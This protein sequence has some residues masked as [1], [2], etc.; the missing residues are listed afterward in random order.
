VVLRQAQDKDD[1]I[2]KPM[3]KNREEAG[4]SLGEKIKREIKKLEI[5]KLLVLAIP[6][7]GVVVGKELADKLKAPLDII[8]TKK[9]G[10]P[11]NSELAIG[12]VGPGGEEVV[13]E[14][15]AEQVGADKEYIKSQKVKIEEEIERREKELRGDK[16][17]LDFKEKTVILTDDGVA[18]G[19]T[20]LAAIEVSR[21]HQPKKIIVAVPVIARDTVSKLEAQVD[22]VVYL[23]AP[24]MFFAVGQFYREFPQVSDEEVKELL[25]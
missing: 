13:D 19:A 25:R 18:T 10:A 2:I 3:F 8:I 23:E 12:A 5:K 4:K 20:M 1:G 17:Q 14:R 9:I 11:G 7:G 15:L 22:V 21:Q 24:L 16:P 6:R